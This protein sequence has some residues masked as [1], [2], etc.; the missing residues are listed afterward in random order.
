MIAETFE[1]TWEGITTDFQGFEPTNMR[2]RQS[3]CFVEIGVVCVVPNYGDFQG[4]TFLTLDVGAG[5]VDVRE[6]QVGPQRGTGGECDPPAR[7]GLD[8]LAFV[9]VIWDERKDFWWDPGDGR[10]RVLDG[11]NQTKNFRCVLLKRVQLNPFRGY[12]SPAW[13]MFQEGDV[14][15]LWARAHLL[16]NAASRS[17]LLAT[18]KSWGIEQL[19]PG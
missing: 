16:P 2:S 17:F 13:I 19:R 5:F 18:C 6:V 3:G 14:S 4:G 9:V 12:G 10:E 7:S 1:G 11:P 15:C 8:L